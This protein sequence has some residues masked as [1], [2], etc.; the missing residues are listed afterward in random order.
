[1]VKIGL[2]AVRNIP[3]KFALGGNVGG[4]TPERGSPVAK[5]NRGL[6]EKPLAPGR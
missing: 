1:L 2:L 6:G 5:A 3:R 4:R